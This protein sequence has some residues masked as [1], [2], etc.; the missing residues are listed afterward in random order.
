M[1]GD[2]KLFAQ[3]QAKKCGVKLKFQTRTLMVG[4]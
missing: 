4:C 1:H 3:D 2:T